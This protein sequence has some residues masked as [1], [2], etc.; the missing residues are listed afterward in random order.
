MLS[1]FFGH[2]KFQPVGALSNILIFT[3]VNMRV[4][5]AAFN[6]YGLVLQVAHV[7]VHVLPAHVRAAALLP[8][9]E[10]QFVPQ[11]SEVQPR[12]RL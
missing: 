6:F 9:A 11:Q 1:R 3:F 7:H 4:R 12:V 8:L 5:I 2:G 10:V